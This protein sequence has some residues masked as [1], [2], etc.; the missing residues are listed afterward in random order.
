M[1]TA[2]DRRRCAA[3]RVSSPPTRSACASTKSSPPAHPTPTRA[4]LEPPYPA[5]RADAPGERPTARVSPPGARPPPCV[6]SR[7]GP[8]RR[9][10]PHSITSRGPRRSPPEVAA[11]PHPRAGVRAGRQCHVTRRARRRRG[12]HLAVALHGDARGHL[13][14]GHLPLLATT[15]SP[16]PPI[17]EMAPAGAPM[18]TDG[19][20]GDRSHPHQP[21]HLA[22]PAQP[23]RGGLQAHAGGV[24]LGSGWRGGATWKGLPSSFFAPL[25]RGGRG[26][27]V[28]M[29]GGGGV[30][31]CFRNGKHGHR[32]F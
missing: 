7:V 26:A 10:R 20:V 5:S 3:R 22:L 17:L 24:A 18:P 9:R 19:V 14:L 11:R 30:D 1:H 15:I 32:I 16:S 13:A 25:V 23:D 29:G 2:A 6:L 28:C 12:A 21:R 27:H 4:V 8:T 31:I